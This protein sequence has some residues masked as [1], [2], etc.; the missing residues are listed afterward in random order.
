MLRDRSRILIYGFYFIAS[1]QEDREFSVIHRLYIYYLFV[2]KLKFT[3]RYIC[4]PIMQGIQFMGVRQGD[5]ISPKLFINAMEDACK[6]LDWKEFDIN[7]NGE[8]ITHLRF[9]DDNVVMTKS[10]EEL[11]TML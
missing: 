8:F 4:N 3:I 11:S 1:W 5:V 10:L 2:N 6:L 7:I 9:A